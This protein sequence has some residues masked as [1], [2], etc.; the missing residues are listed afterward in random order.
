M[1]ETLASK[2]VVRRSSMIMFI[3][4]NYVK[5]EEKED[6][7]L[8]LSL[9]LSLSHTHTHTHTRQPIG[10]YSLLYSVAVVIRYD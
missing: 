7:A 10:I 3:Q 1:F 8:S 9:S 5:E 4:R 6:V 2:K